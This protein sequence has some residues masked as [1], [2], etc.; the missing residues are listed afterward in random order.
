MDLEILKSILSLLLIALVMNATTTWAF[1]KHYC[2]M[3][4]VSKVK[5]INSESCCKA[6]P[7]NIADHRCVMDFTPPECCEIEMIQH[8]G[9][10]KIH[11]QRDR[12][13]V[14]GKKL[15]RT[16]IHLGPLVETVTVMETLGA[17]IEPLEPIV[18]KNRGA[19]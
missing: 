15:G 13:K 16:R 1:A 6:M 8:K 14:I 19:A 17:N 11:D 9:I 3:S 12:I 4:G 7:I 2:T 18:W 10:L 5:F